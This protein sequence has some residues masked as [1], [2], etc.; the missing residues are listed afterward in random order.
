MEVSLKRIAGSTI[1]LVTS[2]NSEKITAAIEENEK[3]IELLQ[4]NNIV[5]ILS[6]IEKKEESVL[7][8]LQGSNIIDF[9][10]ELALI[11]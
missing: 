9:L 8:R 7:E 10:E 5:E 4:G 6:F 2:E 3:E 1:I 11:E